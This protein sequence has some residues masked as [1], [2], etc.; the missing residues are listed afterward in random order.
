[1]STSYASSIGAGMVIDP[2]R[3]IMENLFKEYEAVLIESL[4]TSF[5]LDFLIQDQHGGDVDTIHNVRQIGIDSEMKYKNKYNEMEYEMRGEYNSRE[6]HQHETY[7][8]INKKY[9]EEKRNGTL[10]DAYTGKRIA[11]NEKSDLDHT[12]AAKEIHEDRG[13]I[14]SGIK[15]SDLANCEENLKMTNA[16]TNRSKKADS[17]GVYLDKHGSEYTEAQKARMKV[18]DQK[19]REN[20]EYKIAK[21]YYT[22]KSFM[23]DSAKSVTKL[24]VKMGIKTVLGYVFLEVW[25]SV[26][27]VFQK[28]KNNFDEKSF[29]GKL[30]DGIKNGIQRAKDKYEV[31][32]QKLKEGFVAGAL[33]SLTTTIC[34][35]FLTTGKNIVK[36]IRQIYGTL[37]QAA[38]ILFINPDNLSLG[39]RIKAASK[40]IATGAS[41]IIGTLVTESVS[42]T[43]I[44]TIP[45]VGEIVSTFCGTFVAGLLSCT[46]LYIIDNNIIFQKLFQFINNMSLYS[47]EVNYYRQ[48]AEY[49]E[50]YAAELM[51]IDVRKLKEEVARFEATVDKI[52]S[53]K[54]EWE[55]NSI[56]QNEYERLG[57]NLPWKGDFNEFMSDKNSVLVFE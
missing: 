51:K 15:G 28:A 46:L 17:M 54:N 27:E 3:S 37:V 22:S 29:F 45:V 34:N 35:I 39:E 19:A 43:P 40:L 2:N 11:R 32:L 14:L 53:A 55:L 31:L 20:Y 25:Y 36:I 18:I 38:K 44:G 8:A 52:E 42:K 49:F 26:K 10:Y 21:E 9:S 56:L 5:G 12:I 16:H 48:Q 13:R 6:Y 1:M 30:V 24:G 4:V 41:I 7:R 33:S 50:Q 23:K 47:T 57:L